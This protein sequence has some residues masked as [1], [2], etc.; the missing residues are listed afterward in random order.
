MLPDDAVAPA[1]DPPLPELP[2][3][4]L[5]PPGPELLL[6]EP[7]PALLLAP[8]SELP[9]IDAPP[10]PAAPCLLSVD[11]DLPRLLSRKSVTYQP[12]PLSWKPAAVTCLT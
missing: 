8:L 7:E 3:P 10:W 11:A 2:A 9:E 5:L 12:V 1:P 4:E 6:P